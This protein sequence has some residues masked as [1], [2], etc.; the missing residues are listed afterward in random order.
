MGIFEM[1]CWK[2]MDKNG[3]TNGVKSEEVLQR[4]KQE[5]DTLHVIK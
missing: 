4:I 3:Y 5:K 1:W 2:R